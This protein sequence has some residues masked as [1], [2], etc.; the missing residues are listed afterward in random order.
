MA[1]KT[2]QEFSIMRLKFFNFLGQKNKFTLKSFTVL[3]S[4]PEMRNLESGDIA[5]VRTQAVWDL[6]ALDGYWSTWELAQMRTVLSRDAV[7]M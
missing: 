6:S 3:S 1:H 7:A 2:F 4:E 5:T